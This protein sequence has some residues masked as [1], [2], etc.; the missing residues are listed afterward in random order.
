MKVVSKYNI[1]V[2][3]R[4]SL[5]M[6]PDFEPLCMAKVGSHFAVWV[7]ESD[8]LPK[9][10]VGLRLVPDGEECGDGDY[11]GSVV[12]YDGDLALHLFRSAGPDRTMEE[13]VRGLE[14]RVHNLEG[15]R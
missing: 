3:G 9:V 1:P 6:A 8:D 11:L 14:R 12:E 7:R 10:P 5:E 4:F 2:T 15:H 13:R